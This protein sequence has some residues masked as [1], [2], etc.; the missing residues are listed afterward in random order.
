VNSFGISSFRT[1]PY[2]GAAAFLRKLKLLEETSLFKTTKVEIH[3]FI[4]TAGLKE[5]V[6]LVLPQGLITWTFGCRYKIVVSPEAED[7]PES[8]PVFCMDETVK[9]RSLFEISKGSFRD[10]EHS[11]NRRVAESELWAPFENILYIGDGDT[12]VPALSLVRNQGGLG[13]VVYDPAKS[14][15]EVDRR[16]KTMRLDKRA[17]LITPAKFGVKDELFEYLAARCRQIA[18]RYRAQQLA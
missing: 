11:V 18:L 6:E 15:Q 16:L 1:F 8:V 9:T 13:V 2:D 10:K 12:D 17:D 5:L 7:E 3:F 14:K 4:I